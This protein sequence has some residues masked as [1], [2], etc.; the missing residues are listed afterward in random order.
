MW[1]SER[2]GASRSRASP[3]EMA[4]RP[5]SLLQIRHSLHQRKP[6]NEPCP[7]LPRRWFLLPWCREQRRS[8]PVL[9]TLGWS[10][11]S[12]TARAAGRLRGFMPRRLSVTESFA[13]PHVVLASLRR[14]VRSTGQSRPESFWTAE[15]LIPVDRSRGRLDLLFE[16]TR[17]WRSVVFFVQRLS[18]RTRVEQRTARLRGRLRRPERRSL[19]EVYVELSADCLRAL[20]GLGAG[21]GA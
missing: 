12:A 6:G 16:C 17:V 13:G 8:G 1:I 3:F 15:F 11:V 19:A 14:A 7:L 10:A 5:A 20:T 18:R 21:C 4:G 2:L 9:V